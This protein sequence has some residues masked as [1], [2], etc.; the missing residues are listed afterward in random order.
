MAPK[1]PSQSQQPSSKKS[2]PLTSEEIHKIFDEVLGEISDKLE[3]KL[4]KDTYM[5]YINLIWERPVKGSNSGFQTIHALTS[6]DDED[7]LPEYLMQMNSSLFA[8]P[9]VT[10]AILHQSVSKFVESISSDVE[11]KTSGS[12]GFEYLNSHGGEVN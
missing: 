5:C 4:G 10:N 7:Q 2:D 8:D 11:Q 9:Y 3:S 6:L 12:K 1:N